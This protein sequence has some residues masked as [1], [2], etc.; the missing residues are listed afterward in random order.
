MYL[1]CS[2]QQTLTLL[3]ALLVKCPNLS[4]YGWITGLGEHLFATLNTCDVNA[5]ARLVIDNL[6]LFAEMPLLIRGPEA[7]SEVD[8]SWPDNG[9]SFLASELARFGK[10]KDLIGWFAIL[11]VEDAQWIGA[12]F[13]GAKRIEA[14][15]DVATHWF[16]LLMAKRTV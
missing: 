7:M 14:V 13:F 11:A 9:A 16:S 4:W 8:F 1:C 2:G 3:I 5:Q 6:T 12:S 10:R 15:L